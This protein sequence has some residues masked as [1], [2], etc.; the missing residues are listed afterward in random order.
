MSEYLFNFVMNMEKRW[1]IIRYDASMKRMWDSFVGQSRQGTML[2]LRGYMDYH[3]DR[4]ADCSLVALRDGKPTAILAANI[5]ADGT[6]HSHQ[7]LTY[8]GWLTPMRHFNAN[9]MLDVFDAWIGWCKKEGIGK[10]FYK[11]VPSVY[12][13]IPAE[14]DLYALFRHGA[15]LEAMNLSSAVDLSS[16]VGFNTLQ[17]RHLRKAASMSPWIKETSDAEEFMSLVAMCLMER[18]NARPVHTAAEMQRLKD[19]FPDG[20]RMFLC[21]VS[22]APEAGVCVYDS[23]GVAHCQYIAT[24]PQGREHGMLTF[25]MHH[26]MTKTFAGRRWFDLGTSNEDSGRILN[27][28]LIRQKSA[29]GGSGIAY[30]QYFLPLSNS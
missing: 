21:G 27:A 10:I 13:R 25:L 4:F 5:T 8:G 6:L 24:S 17:H 3:S 18:H 29:L 16:P 14:E 19:A 11:P 1:E 20:I 28:G 30:P 15:R 23:A 7:G 26:L 2:H 12:H 22:D 9:D